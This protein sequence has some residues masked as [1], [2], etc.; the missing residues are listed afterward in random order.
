MRRVKPIWIF[1][2]LVLLMAVLVYDVC[3]G[4]TVWVICQP[5]SFVYIRSSPRFRS[6]EVAYLSVGDAL[7]TDGKTNGPWIHVYYFCEAGEGWIY[8]GYVTNS[9][10]EIYEKGLRAVTGFRNVRARRNVN[11]KLRR[12]LKKGTDLLAYVVSDEWT[13]TN[14]GFIRTR[15]LDFGGVT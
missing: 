5:D 6:Q 10:P 13:I 8:K 12:T 15:Y 11:G 4:E 7:E 9:K 14:A 2:I 1:I 3:R